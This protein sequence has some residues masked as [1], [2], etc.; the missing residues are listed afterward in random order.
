MA[1]NGIIN[2]ISA[3]QAAEHYEHTT[4]LGSSLTTMSLSPAGGAACDV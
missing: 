2:D 3:T 4:Y 1:T